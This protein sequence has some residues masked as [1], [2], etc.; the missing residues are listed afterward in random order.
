M[1]SRGWVSDIALFAVQ[2][3]SSIPRCALPTMVIL[4]RGITFER[5]F[6]VRNVGFVQ[7]SVGMSNGVYERGNTVHDHLTPDDLAS[8]GRC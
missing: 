1:R 6:T 3:V 5:K 7:K 8:G 2:C 4:V